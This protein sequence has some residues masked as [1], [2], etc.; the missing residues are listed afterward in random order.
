MCCSCLLWVSG[1]YHCL[2]ELRDLINEGVHAGGL[3]RGRG[4]VGVVLGLADVCGAGLAGH[5]GAC[6]VAAELVAVHER[7]DVGLGFAQE[8]RLEAFEVLLHV[9][10][11]EGRDHGDDFLRVYHDVL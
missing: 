7:A 11:D 8:A 1:A 10:D 4:G 3:E 9:L 5:G 6:G 2:L